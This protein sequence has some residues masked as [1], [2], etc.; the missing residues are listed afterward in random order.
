MSNSGVP[1]EV[2]NNYIAYI[3]NACK[4]YPNLVANK[5]VEV[6]WLFGENP[7]AGVIKHKFIKN[8]E[9]T[10]KIIDPNTKIVKTLNNLFEKEN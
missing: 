4:N 7:E 3:K 6:V 5:I 8:E 9:N 2:I 1:K 10:D